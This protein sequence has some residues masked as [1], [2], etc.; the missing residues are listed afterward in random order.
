MVD[1]G[2]NAEAQQD[3][4]ENNAHKDAEIPGQ[5]LVFLRQPFRGTLFR[6]HAGGEQLMFGHAQHGADVPQ[7]GHIRVTHASLPF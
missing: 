3:P 6:I 2:R 7:Q 1:D 4:A 5:A